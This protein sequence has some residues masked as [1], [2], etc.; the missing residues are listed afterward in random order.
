MKLSR[1]LLWITLLLIVLAAVLRFKHTRRAQPVT[2]PH[3]TTSASPT[4]APST[5]PTPAPSP[6]IATPSPAPAPAPAATSAASTAST[7]STSASDPIIIQDGTTIDFSSG[8][9]VIIDST[10]DPQLQADLAE[11]QA[12]LE[13]LEAPPSANHPDAPAPTPSPQPAPTP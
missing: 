13:E 6:I 10:N 12:A 1:P 9:A 8:Q 7:A 4:H 11:M 2:A 5:V 3:H